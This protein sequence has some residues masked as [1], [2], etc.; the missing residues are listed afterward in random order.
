[1]APMSRAWRWVKAPA[2]DEVPTG[3]AVA[4][5]FLRVLA[6]LLW[7]YNV[8]WK[9]APD[10]GR[11]DGNG[12]YRFTQDAVDHPVL[13]PYSWLVEH[14]V[15]PSFTSFGWGV[16][17]AETALAVLLLTGA[18]VRLAALLGVA[19]SLAIGLSVAATPGEWP[20]AY[21]M[22]IGIHVVLLFSAAGRVFAVDA[23]RAGLRDGRGLSLGWG[24]VSVVAGLVAGARA[25]SDP[26]ASRGPT[27]GGSELSIG[28]GAYNLAGSLLLLGI[29]AG[30]ILLGRTQVPAAA[31]AVVALGL[32]AALTL[33]VQLGFGG[34]WLGGTP[35]SAAYFLSTALV[36]WAVLRWASGSGVPAEGRDG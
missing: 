19:Q 36:A 7:L 3:H 31:W 14:V 26:W 25:L 27:L 33:H 22:M 16:L 21:W 13:P 10:F 4:A 28:L 34:P 32:L 12:L 30:L 17:A 1:M 2:V 23:V 24:V 9:R 35:T 29:G 6:G 11:D 15:L 20:W 18:Y 5:A 8:S